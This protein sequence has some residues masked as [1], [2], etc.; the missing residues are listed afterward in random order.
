MPRDKKISISNDKI[1]NVKNKIE[2]AKKV[3]NFEIN[4]S[5]T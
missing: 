3:E 4:S 1:T 5:F 2:T